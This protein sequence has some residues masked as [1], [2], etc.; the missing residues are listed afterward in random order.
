MIDEETLRKL[1][2]MGLSAM[3]DA[4]RE[5]LARPGDDL[6]FSERVGI[7]IDREWSARENRKLNRLLRAAKLGIDACLEDVWCKPERGLNKATLRDLATC[8]WIEDKLNVILVGK[9]GCGKSYIGAALAQ[10]AC[11][12]GRRALCARVPR[13][14]H[15]L[16]IARGDGSYTKLLARLAKL[17]VL[18]LDDFLIAPLKDSERRDIL[19]VLEDRYGKSSTVISSQLETAKWHA[20]L[21]DPTVADAICD[22]L[23]HNAHVMALTGPSIRKLQGTHKKDHHPNT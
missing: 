9:T 15:D 10:A 13:L 20:A 21:G 17:D 4:L 11:R 23:V 1:L 12:S 14:V 7:V 8:R 18:V 6:S 22:R 2:Q 5:Q 3:A 19:E 16:A